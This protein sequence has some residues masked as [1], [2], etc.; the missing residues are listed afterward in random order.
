MIDWDRV[1]QTIGQGGTDEF[2]IPVRNDRRG[3][4]TVGDQRDSSWASRFPPA[5]PK[6]P[7]R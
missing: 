2:S 7:P 4:L 5:A 1:H 6:T 3:R